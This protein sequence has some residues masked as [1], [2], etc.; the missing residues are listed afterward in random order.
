MNSG[1]WLKGF[2]CISMG[3]WALDCTRKLKSDPIEK[4]G[5]HEIC[6]TRMARGRKGCLRAKWHILGRGK[7]TTKACW[8]VLFEYDQHVVVMG[9]VSIGVSKEMVSAGSCDSGH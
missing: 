9:W 1:W 8:S 6:R 5:W 4:D 7:F 2:A 3:L